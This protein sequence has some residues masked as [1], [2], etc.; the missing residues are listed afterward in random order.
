MCKSVNCQNENVIDG[1]AD[2]VGPYNIND[3]S[4]ESFNEKIVCMK[5]Y[6]YDERDLSQARVTLYARH[7]FALPY[8]GTFLV[9]QYNLLDL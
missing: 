8:S 4:Y 5:I 9:G 3:L 1:A 7:N 6:S 2:V